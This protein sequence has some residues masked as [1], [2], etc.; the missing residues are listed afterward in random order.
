V[1]T[2]ASAHSARSVLRAKIAV[3]LSP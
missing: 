2:A 1:S 3:L